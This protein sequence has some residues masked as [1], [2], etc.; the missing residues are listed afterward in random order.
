MPL[1]SLPPKLRRTLLLG[2]LCTLVWAVPALAHEEDAPHELRAMIDVAKEQVLSGNY[3][4]AEATYEDVIRQAAT[5]ECQA[6][7]P[8]EGLP[9]LSQS[10]AILLAAMILLAGAVA[11]QSRR[12][13]RTALLGVVL[14]FSGTFLFAALDEA[15][16]HYTVN[17]CS[18]LLGV[19]SAV[20]Y[21][22]CTPVLGTWAPAADEYVSQQTAHNCENAINQTVNASITTQTHDRFAASLTLCGIDFGEFG[23]EQESSVTFT[24]S[25]NCQINLT[26]DQPCAGGVIEYRWTRRQRVGTFYAKCCDCFWPYLCFDCGG[27]DNS[28]GHNDTLTEYTA[29]VCNTRSMTTA[30]IQAL[31]PNC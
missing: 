21:D 8:P 26:S 19:C 10:T 4:A 25:S 29:F 18:G 31:C 14:T 23:V 28:H 11:V 27:C 20:W 30:E 5:Q 6:C 13:R 2:S 24:L 17:A 16:A 3:V 15:G 12:F 1:C 22:E 7:S 9:A